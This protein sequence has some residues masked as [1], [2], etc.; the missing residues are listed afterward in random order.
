MPAVQIRNITFGV[1][2]PDSS[3]LGIAIEY[4]IPSIGITDLL[5]LTN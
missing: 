1:I 5:E 2:N 4:S 3:Y